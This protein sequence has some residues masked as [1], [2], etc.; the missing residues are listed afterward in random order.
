MSSE[1]GTKDGILLRIMRMEDYPQV[2]IFMEENFFNVE[3][4]N[5]DLGLDPKNYHNSKID[6]Y[7]ISLIEQGTCVV[8]LDEQNDGKLVGF[9]LAGEHT[10]EDGEKIRQDAAATGHNIEGRILALLSMVDVKVKLFERYG[11]SKALY[12]HVTNV[13]DS[14]RGKGLG[15]RLAA[16]LM[17]VGRSK[18]YPVMFAY[19][20]SF[21]SARQ[22]EQLGMECI[23]QLAYTDYK[24]EKGEMIFKPPHPH[25]HIRAMVIKLL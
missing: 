24:D 25:T 22:K 14:M 6:S 2:K 1:L 15:L 20:S 8:A 11:I 18:G 13:D 21:Y 16:A 9:V 5:A 7:Q 12:S 17:E 23:Y 10:P 3:P 4:L 19:C